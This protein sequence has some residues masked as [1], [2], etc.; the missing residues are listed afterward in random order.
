MNPIKRLVIIGLGLIGGS[1]ALA[2]KRAGAVQTVVG[3]SRRTETLDT[4][5]EL[6]VIDEKTTDWA[7]ALDAADV[8]VLAAPIG[9]TA[10]LL[11]TMQPHLQANTVITDVGSVKGHIVAA[12]QQV[13]GDVPAQLVPGHPIAGSERSGVT[14]ASASLFEHHKVILTP[15]PNTSDSAQQTVT[16]LWQHTGA[17]VVTMPVD[18]HDQVLAH[19]SHL[20]HLLAFALVD[21]LAQQP[22]SDAMFRYAAGGFRDFTRIAASDPQMWHDIFTGN[23]TAVLTALDRLTND[24]QTLR[25]AIQDND[26]ET[27]LETLARAQTARQRC[28]P[29]FNKTKS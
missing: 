26:G 27:I 5:L 16:H 20:P 4:A 3:I 21:S 9:V 17:D 8:V 14:A 11:A 22:D 23:R 6:G 12:A 28:A 24:L 18:Q 15:L 2:L 19:T 25:Q 13:F 29:W 1:L 7:V 10:D